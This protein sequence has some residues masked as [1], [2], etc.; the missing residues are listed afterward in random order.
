[1]S[2]TLIVQNIFQSNSKYK[3]VTVFSKVK[4]FYSVFSIFSKSPKKPYLLSFLHKNRQ[5]LPGNVPSSNLSPNSQ[6]NPSNNSNQIQPIEGT[7][8][9]P[10]TR[11][12]KGNLTNIL[13]S[14]GV[15]TWKAQH[16]IADGR[17]IRF[18]ERQGEASTQK[19]NLVV[20]LKNLILVRGKVTTNDVHTRLPKSD[21]PKIFQLIYSLGVNDE[22][23]SPNQPKIQLCMAKNEQEQ[24][25][26][27][28]FLQKAMENNRRQ[29]QLAGKSNINKS[30]SHAGQFAKHRNNYQSQNQQQNFGREQNNSNNQNPSSSG[31]PTS[32]HMNNY[33][34]QPTLDQQFQAKSTSNVIS[35]QG[36]PGPYSTNVHH[37][38]QFSGSDHAHFRAS[39]DNLAKFGGSNMM[40][41]STTNL[42][43]G[44]HNSSNTPTTGNLTGSGHFNFSNQNLH[45]NQNTSSLERDRAISPRISGPAGLSASK[46]NLNTNNNNNTNISHNHRQSPLEFQNQKHSVT[47]P[48]LNETILPSY[49]SHR[50][51]YQSP[52]MNRHNNDP[53]S[54]N[55]QNYVG[56]SVYPP[57]SNLNNNHGS[58]SNQTTP[59]SNNNIVRHSN[60]R[61]N[62]NSNN[63]LNSSYDEEDT[64]TERPIPP[65]RK[66]HPYKNLQNNENVI[67]PKPNSSF[68]AYS[69]AN[70]NS[71]QIQNNH[72][73][74]GQ[75]NLRSNNNSENIYNNN[76]QN[77]GVQ[78]AVS[79]ASQYLHGTP[80][81]R[82]RGKWNEMNH[83]NQ[84]P[85][86]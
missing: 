12:A 51:N 37:Q 45:S 57:N 76:N 13:L 18:Y 31:T 20:E 7:L 17:C 50:Y 30:K 60:S 59:N 32:N 21:L 5:F 75:I 6:V 10:K 8:S 70:N 53:N 46:G 68:Q 83:S 19:A 56:S 38:H 15:P 24:S 81:P 74:Y 43:N 65:E 36:G 69:K 2:N 55:Y 34:S 16:V 62:I 73:F 67:E 11:R 52:Q 14:R 82:P 25:V 41:K 61:H 9:I 33:H 77:S 54:G 28:D 22:N 58:N 44:G 3:P 4:T 71:S 79:S 35:G 26:W 48:N 63:N 27:V 80:S 29:M 64:L 39:Q 42:P 23:A 47:T 66:N 1:M 84:G 72:H 40:A 49:S 85:V 78:R 86:V